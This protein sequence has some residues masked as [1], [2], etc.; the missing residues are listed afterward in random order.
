MDIITTVIRVPTASILAMVFTFLVSVG[1]PIALCIYIRRKYKAKISSFF[2]GCAAFI[3]FALILEQ[4]LHLLVLRGLGSISEA[5]VGNVWLYGLYGGLAAGIF[6]ETG[7]FLSMKFL[8]KK[9]Q[10][11]ENALMYGAGHGGVEAFILIGITYFANLLNSVLLNMGM[12]DELLAGELGET[13]RPGYEQLASY[14]ASTFALAGIERLMAMTLHI[15]LSVLVYMA[16]TKG[17]ENIPGKKIGYY[18]LAIG[19]HALVNFAVVVAASIFSLVVAELVC[20]VLVALV[21]VIAF[22]VWRD[23]ET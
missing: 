15:A 13:A 22:R 17:K 8:M 11:R 1:V 2:I 19:L 23:C 14:P 21:V 10:S 20:L 12:L 6:E 3:V 4:F 18:F 16:V 9:N 5:I 7:R